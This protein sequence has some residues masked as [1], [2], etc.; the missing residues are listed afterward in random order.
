MAENEPPLPSPGDQPASTFESKPE[1]ESDKDSGT[2]VDKVSEV[3][4]EPIIRTPSPEP[5]KP[6]DPEPSGGGKEPEP[7][8]HGKDEPELPT[9]DKPELPTPDKPELPTPDKPELPTPDKPDPV[10]VRDPNDIEEEIPKI[11]LAGY[12]SD[13]DA[14]KEE[15]LL[16]DA[17]DVQ[18]AQSHA[19]EHTS[20]DSH[21]V[22][23]QSNEA[24]VEK[25]ATPIGTKI[26]TKPLPKKPT[27]PAR[28][29]PAKT[30]T[31][32]NAPAPKK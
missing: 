5:V 18:F 6:N 2:P 3:V 10:Y 1:S 15:I 14:P 29:I 26:P 22:V 20:H 16:D 25:K 8:D 19:V 32:E 4:P 27:T 7:S 11:I 23:Q 31:K 9:P 13:T 12:T 30:P 28:S 17:A 21:H 24:A